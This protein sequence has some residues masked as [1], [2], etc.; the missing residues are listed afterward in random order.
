MRKIAFI[1]AAIAS[2][3]LFTRCASTD[4]ATSDNVNQSEI[5]QS[6]TVVYDANDKELSATATFRFGGPTGTT[7]SLAKPSIVS[8][9]GE[10]MSVENSV[11]TG[12]YYKMAKQTG[13]VNSCTFVFIDTQKKEY[14]NTAPLM[15]AEISEY[16]TNTDKATGFTINWDDPLR[17]GETVTFNIEDGK[18]NT[19]SVSVNTQGA[20]RLSVKPEDLKE[21]ETGPCRVW[22][23][24]VSELA[25]KQATHLE[26]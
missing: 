17:P 1:F 22:L 7:L 5:H 18:S 20:T 9:N 14:I 8:F 26:G 3:L 25:L 16:P 11:F 24:R 13:F 10:A 23:V 12:T 2:V 6:Y 4:T 15:A 19:A 21:I